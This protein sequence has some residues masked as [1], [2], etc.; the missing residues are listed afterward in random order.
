MIQI[1][2]T[3]T[4]KAILMTL[5]VNF[6][7]T[8]R[9]KITFWSQ[10]TT[11]KTQ[12]GFYQSVAFSKSLHFSWK[13]SAGDV[14]SSF[15]NPSDILSK[16]G[17][18][19]FYHCPRETQSSFLTKLINSNCFLGHVRRKFD[20]SAEKAEKFVSISQ[21]DESQIDELVHFFP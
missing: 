9:K 19:I 12:K 15:D 21:I 20:N 3:E 16:E 17:Q 7:R 18:K 6:R 4:D 1:V 5:L 10:K 2:L 11:K 14:E 8:S 13:W